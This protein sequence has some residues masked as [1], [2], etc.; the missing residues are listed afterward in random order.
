M[1]HGWRSRIINY[2]RQS[3]ARPLSKKT[4]ISQ[5]H[6]VT[7]CRS[8]VVRLNKYAAFDVCCVIFLFFLFFLFASRLQ[9]NFSIY[10]RLPDF[11]LCLLRSIFSASNAASNEARATAQQAKSVARLQQNPILLTPTWPRSA[12]NVSPRPFLRRVT[13]L[14]RQQI[15]QGLIFPP[16]NKSPSASDCVWGRI[17][18]AARK[19]NRRAPGDERR[20]RFKMM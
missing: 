12:L 15:Y 2:S 4:H 8:S 17:P 14:A 13:L 11:T 6:S 16:P 7:S 18:S 5:T 3:R 1:T 19:Q 9:A 20:T 10:S